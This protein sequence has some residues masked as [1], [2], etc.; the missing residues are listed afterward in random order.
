[1]KNGGW[2]MTLAHISLVPLILSIFFLTLAHFLLFFNYL[3]LQAQ[4]EA[5][6]ARI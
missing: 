6:T 5:L 3:Q 2:I 4:V 1:M